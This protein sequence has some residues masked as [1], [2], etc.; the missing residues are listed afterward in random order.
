MRLI[1]PRVLMSPLPLPAAASTPVSSC[2]QPPLEAF[3][4]A[5]ALGAASAGG[6]LRRLGQKAASMHASEAR[7]PAR[8]QAAAAE[9]IGCGGGWRHGRG[10]HYR[11]ASAYVAAHRAQLAQRQRPISSLARGSCGD[12]TAPASARLADGGGGADDLVKMR[13]VPRFH[14]ASDPQPTE[15]SSARLPRGQRLLTA[16]GPLGLSSSVA[17]GTASRRQRFAALEQRALDQLAHR[18]RPGASHGR[19]RDFRRRTAG[20]A[21][22]RQSSS[23]SPHPRARARHC[24]SAPARP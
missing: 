21:S 24:G 16:A 10:S 17:G 19:C 7:S 4:S 8:E 6:R 14:A 22:G 15:R 9:A 13:R 12:G 5:R 3:A 20:S 2:G 1:A 11:I 23:R 18:W